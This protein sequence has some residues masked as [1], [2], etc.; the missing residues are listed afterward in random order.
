[1]TLPRVHFAVAG[2]IG[3][4]TGGYIY[5]ARIADGLKALGWPLRVHELAGRHPEADA[6][7]ER[8]AAA[9]L[10]AVGPGEMLL[11]DGLALPAF[12]PALPRL[13]DGA[14]LVALIHHPLADETGVDEVSRRRLDGAERAALGHAAR[15]IVTSDT[16]AAAVAGMG[17]PA[18]RIGTVRPGV[19]AAPRVSAG[20]AR[21]EP[22]RLDLLC[23]ATITPRK[24]HALLVEALAG[25]QD[26]P[27]RLTCI[28][29]DTRDPATAAALRDLIGRHGL[30]DR[31]ALSGERPATEMS[32]AYAA[33]DLF[34]LPS[35]HEGF[36]MAFAEAL[37][38][39]IPVVGT[40]AGAIP[41]TVPADAGILVP[42]GDV[43]ALR[44]ALRRLLTDPALLRG[45]R[46]GA[47]RA[48]FPTW[49]DAARAFARQLELAAA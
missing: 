5:D 38:Q 2:A 36:G 20:R 15:V 49:D 14:R 22:Q 30:E 43:D 33:A 9:C 10:E 47:A 8:A 13:A 17:V 12:L 11:V 45:L 39:G 35:F 44:E 32:A 16:T 27:W 42:P 18:G 40:T 34:V 28:G 26:L 3:Q 37:T 23:V 24:G 7:A 6:L 48:Q 1:M 19:D 41:E 21:S 4:I 31:I 46:Q 25:L 29:S